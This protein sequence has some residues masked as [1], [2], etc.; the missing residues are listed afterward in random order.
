MGCSL[1]KRLHLGGDG[2]DDVGHLDEGLDLVRLHVQV[3]DVEQLLETSLGVL[4][5]RVNRQPDVLELH[6]LIICSS[7]KILTLSRV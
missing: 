5:V 1:I 7:P 6:R 2:G 3:E 4:Q